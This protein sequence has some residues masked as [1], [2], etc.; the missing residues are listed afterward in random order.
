MNALVIVAACSSPTFSRDDVKEIDATTFREMLTCPDG[1]CE[2]RG[3]VTSIQIEPLGRGDARYLVT[4]SATKVATLVYAEYPG[5]V[6]DEI[7]TAK[8]PYTIASKVL[9]E[10][11]RSRRAQTH[12]LDVATFRRVLACGQEHPP[13]E[14]TRGIEQ[15]EV[16]PVDEHNARY[17]ITYKNRQRHDLVTAEFGTELVDAIFAAH[18]PYAVRERDD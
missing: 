13:C 16:Q 15:I 9:P 2:L 8:L 3:K 1:N 17:D 6:V 18:I 4:W 7:V 14:D 5:H 10:P 12:D 11:R